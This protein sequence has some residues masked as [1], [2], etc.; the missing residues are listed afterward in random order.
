MIPDH[1]VDW[2]DDLDDAEAARLVAGLS[3]EE[4]IGATADWSGWAHPGQVAP[5]GDW[6]TWVLMAGRGYGKTRAGA[7]W[8]ADEVRAAPGIRIAL[9]AA[10][11]DEARRVM[12]EGESGLLAVAAADIAH[13][14][15]AAR[16]LDFMNGATAHLY[17]GGSPERLRGPQHHLAWCDELAKWKHPQAT[18]DMLQMGLRLGERPRTLVTTTPRPIATLRR[19]LALPA[20]AVTGGPTAANPHLPA[21]FLAAMADAYAGTRL[22]RQELNGEL[23][24][25]LPGALWTVDLLERCRVMPAPHLPPVIPAQ[26]G[27]PS[28]PPSED[29]GDDGLERAE[30]APT[31][32]SPHRG[33]GDSAPAERGEGPTPTPP[34]ARTVIGVDPPAGE[35]TC[36][37]VACARDAAGIAHVLADHSVTA[38]SPENWARAVAAA[39]RIH[40]ADLVVAEA[41]QGGKMVEAVL[42]AAEVPARI[43]LVRASD[44]KSARADPVAALFEAGRAKLAGRFPELEAELCGLIAGGGYEGPGISPDRADAMVWG[45]S[46]LMLG[47]REQPAI[48]LL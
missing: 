27:T 43:R 17:G 46:E 7:E 1:L 8:I 35:G 19:L 23:L 39:A 48:R 28:R 12:I 29:T 20:T 3:R 6:R 30:R 31:Q 18:W 40:S 41:N 5:P 24:P 37:I 14:S 44:G 22:A 13:F 47:A 10:S 33:E 32:P 36:G 42:R 21:A 26:A 9:V 25:D 11:I 34:F 4:L 15:Y 2:L 16:R 45:M 38:R